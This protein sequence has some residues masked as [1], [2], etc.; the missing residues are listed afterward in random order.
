MTVRI[1]NPQFESQTKIKLTN[2]EVEGAELRHGRRAREVLRGES[3]DCEDDLPEG[4]RRAEAREAA[5]KARDMARSQNKVW[6]GLPEKLRD[7]RKHDL[8]VS[9]LYLVEGDSAG[10]SADTGRDAAFQAIL[11]LRGKL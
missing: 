5:R 3:A 11:P 2:P 9:E 1:P 4:L 8:E 6:G 7:C 10:G